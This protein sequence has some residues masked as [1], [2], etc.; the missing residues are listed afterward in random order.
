MIA[1]LLGKVVVVTGMRKI[2][3][4]CIR[5]HFYDNMGGKSGHTNSGACKANGS[6]RSTEGIQVTKMRLDSCPLVMVDDGKRKNKPLTIEELRQMDGVPVYWAEEKV[7]GI[8]KVDS[9]GQ[10]KDKPFLIGHWHGTDFERDI[11]RRQLKLY[12]QKPKE[13]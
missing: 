11:E 13:V 5:C 4:C 2:P 8:V 3:K 12:R 7:W 9:N 10:W 1:N 6:Y